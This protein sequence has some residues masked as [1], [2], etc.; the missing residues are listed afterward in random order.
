ML[1]YNRQRT[2]IVNLNVMQCLKLNTHYAKNI[3]DV[4]CEAQEESFLL[5]RYK[6]IDK[7]AIAMNEILKAY[8]EGKRIFCMPAD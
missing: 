4:C 2:E 8:D 3:Y 5:G 6:S 7:A 1:I